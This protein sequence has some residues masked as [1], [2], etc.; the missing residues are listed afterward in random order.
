MKHPAENQSALPRRDGEQQ[1][2][3]RR[4]FLKLAGAG[5][6]AAAVASAAVAHAVSGAL[7]VRED[8]VPAVGTGIHCG[9]AVRD[10]PAAVLDDGAPD[11]GTGGRGQGQSA[12]SRQSRRTM[13]GGPSHPATGLQPRPGA[14]SDAAG[15]RCKCSAMARDKLG[16]GDRADQKPARGDPLRRRSA[17]RGGDRQRH[18]GVGG[19]DDGAIAARLWLGEFHH[20]RVRAAFAWAGFDPGHQRPGGLRFREQPLH[21]EFRRR[22]C[23]KA[24]CRRCARCATSRIFARDG[25]ASAASWCRSRAACRLPRPR[26]TSGYG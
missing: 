15:G 5:T 13:P 20:R 2:I 21:P 9:V 11:R 25:S 17:Y 19:T 8:A 12:R 22:H 16:G 24:G 1:G 23:W 10:V 14:Q 4:D 7:E 3:A 18:V 6:V 26:P